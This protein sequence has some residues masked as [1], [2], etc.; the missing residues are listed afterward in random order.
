V[1]R[2]RG[3]SCWLPFCEA[4]V[5]DEELHLPRGSQ[6]LCPAASTPSCFHFRSGGVS[7]ADVPEPEE[8]SEEQ[9]D[10]VPLMDRSCVANVLEKVVNSLFSPLF[11]K[12]YAHDANEQMNANE[13]STQISTNELSAV[14]F[15]CSQVRVV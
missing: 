3:K 8:G 13:L 15:W 11:L 5:S 10:P 9:L 2:S 1:G 6:R 7:F 12:I 14:Q 4:L